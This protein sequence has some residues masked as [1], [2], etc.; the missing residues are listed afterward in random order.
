MS[1]RDDMHGTPT[2]GELRGRSVN[3]KVFRP[4]N[5]E[6]APGTVRWISNPEHF[7]IDVVMGID[8][9]AV[10]KR[11]LNLYKI[12]SE[13]VPLESVHRI[14]KVLKLPKD[15]VLKYLDIS[16]ATFNRRMKGETKRLTGRESGQVY[17]Y[18]RLISLATNMFHGDQEEALRWLKSPAYAFKGETPL[19]HART[20]Y[21]NNEVET[22]IGRM[23]HG[24]PS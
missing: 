20:E 21:G 15:K 5:E 16:Q 18:S 12:I 1:A 22:L 14:K 2:Q 3:P 19:E 9:D 10:D 23:E 6:V 8:A 11:H 7:F 4:S 24:I 17:R 13:G